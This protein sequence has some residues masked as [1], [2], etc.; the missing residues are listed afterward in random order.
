[1]FGIYFYNKLSKREIRLKLYLYPLNKLYFYYAYIFFP[2][3]YIS[4]V[5]KLCRFF[6]LLL[7]GISILWIPIIETF[8]G[9]ELFIYI[10]AISAYLSPPIAAVYCLAIFWKGMNESVTRYY[11]YIFYYHYYHIFYLMFLVFLTYSF[12]MNTF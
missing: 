1:M 12:A 11:F 9:G 6:I 4:K 10:Q 8:Q 5:I 2:Y 7:V 3:Q